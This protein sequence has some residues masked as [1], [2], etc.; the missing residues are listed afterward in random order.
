MGMKYT[1]WFNNRCIYIGKAEQKTLKERLI[2]YYRNCHND[3]LK[4][5]IEVVSNILISKDIRLGRFRY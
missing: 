5:W 4:L 2:Q 3:D 1:F